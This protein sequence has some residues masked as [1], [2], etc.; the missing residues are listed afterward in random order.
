MSAEVNIGDVVVSV[1]GRDKDKYFLVIEAN[2]KTVRL[3]NGKERKL[4]ASKKKNVKHIK[5]VQ[6]GALIDLAWQINNG[7]SVGNSR[8]QKSINSTSIKK[9]ED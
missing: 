1:R 6:A 4:T 8:L 3:V 2:S 9:Q 7:E 5:S